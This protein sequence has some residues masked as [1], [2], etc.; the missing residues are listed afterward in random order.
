MIAAETCGPKRA[1]Q[2]SGGSLADFLDS[3]RAEDDPKQVA[4]NI[5]EYFCLEDGRFN[6]FFPGVQLA[7]VFLDRT[8]EGPQ[9]EQQKHRCWKDLKDVLVNS[10]TKPAILGWIRANYR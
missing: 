7:V 2:R 9:G 8:L 3:Q 5:F 6:D 4:A 10:G 1:F